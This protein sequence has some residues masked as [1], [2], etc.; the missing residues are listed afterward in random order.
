MTDGKS[1]EKHGV[2][3]DVTALPTA[4]SLADGNDPVMAKAVEIAGGTITPEAAGK[5]FPYKWPRE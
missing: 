1:L 3:P 2:I 4:Q 5:L